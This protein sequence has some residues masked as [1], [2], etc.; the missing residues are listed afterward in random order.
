MCLH[1]A[2]AVEVHASASLLLCVRLHRTPTVEVHT[3]RASIVE[4]H[5]T[6]APIIEIYMAHLLL[7]HVGLHRRRGPPP[8]L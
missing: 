1:R 5:A 6:C 8:M 3:T 4:V 2:L 7:L